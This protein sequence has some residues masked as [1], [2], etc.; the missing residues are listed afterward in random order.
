MEKWIV[1][2]ENISQLIIV[3]FVMINGGYLFYALDR[4]NKMGLRGIYFGEK[5]ICDSPTSGSFQRT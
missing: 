3:Y 4:N 5:I 2:G 1:E